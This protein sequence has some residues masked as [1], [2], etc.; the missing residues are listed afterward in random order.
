M[1]TPGRLSLARRT[2]LSSWRL[3][4]TFMSSW[5]CMIDILLG[6][7]QPKSFLSFFLMRRN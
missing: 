5:N 1:T 2:L 3:W 7:Y 4:E 6:L